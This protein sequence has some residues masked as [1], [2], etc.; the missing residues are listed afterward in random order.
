[1][2]TLED[3]A[4]AAS[5]PNYGPLEASYTPSE[6]RRSAQRFDITTPREAEVV[7]A[8]ENASVSDSPPTLQEAL[9]GT[10]ERNF[11][12]KL[13][14]WKHVES[15]E[16]RVSHLDDEAQ[17]VPKTNAKQSYLESKLCFAVD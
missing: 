2:E 7:A 4:P 16:R 14:Y 5:E 6:P 13:E 3:A 9:E 8:V 12:D 10:P 11:D 17:K 15:L 1:M